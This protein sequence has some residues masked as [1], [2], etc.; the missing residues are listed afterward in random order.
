MAS[1]NV[2]PTN[3]FSAKSNQ[4]H[5]AITGDEMKIFP[6]ISTPE[7]LNNL[8]SE[9]IYKTQLGNVR[10]YFDLYGDYFKSMKFTCYV[11]KGM[12]IPQIQISKFDLD[13][14]NFL[15]Y[16]ETIKE[17]DYMIVLNCE[18]NY[19]FYRGSKDLQIKTGIYY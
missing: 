5:I 2:L 13:D 19:Y 9:K 6:F 16:R 17:K 4:T 3:R 7:Y 1:S 15:K 18:E 14:K 11:R 8:T 10:N 12:Q